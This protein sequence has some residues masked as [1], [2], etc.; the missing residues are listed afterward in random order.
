[1]PSDRVLTADKGLVKSVVLL[2]VEWSFANDEL[3]D[4]EK[5]TSQGGP[6]LVVLNSGLE[7][8][9]EVCLP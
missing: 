7:F 3:E 8:L 9:E 1:M 2:G 6:C 5:E 4:V